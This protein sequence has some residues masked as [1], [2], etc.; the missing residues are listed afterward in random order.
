M[1]QVCVG[2]LLCF[3]SLSQAADFPLSPAFKTLQHPRNDIAFTPHGGAL[4]TPSRSDVLSAI[5]NQSPVRDQSGRGTCSIFSATAALE[6]LLVRGGYAAPGVNLSEEWL[7][8]LTTQSQS[9]EG[10]TSANNFMLLREWGQPLEKSLPYGGQTWTS[11]SS[12]LALRRC[13]YLKRGP[14]LRACLTSHRNPDLLKMNDE[15]LLNPNEV[16]YDPEFVV[17]RKEAL[18]ARDAYL[19]RAN[20]HDGIVTTVSEIHQLLAAGIPLT[21]DI[22]FFWGAWNYPG[23]AE[24]G[25]LRSKEY[26]ENGTITYPEKGSVDRRYS[27]KHPES[28]SVVVVGYDDDVEVTYTMSMRNG[29][30]QI[31]TR[32]GVYYFKNSWGTDTWGKNF[33]VNGQSFPGYGM[34]LQDN[35]HEFGEFYHLDL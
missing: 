3:A 16:Y 23:S 11:K 10:S 9:S 8:Y 24:K 33:Q 4:G 15:E 26:W 18:M 29:K 30:R 12:G 7:Q 32:K 34:I 13:G 28:H 22:D 25:I 27:K 31:F 5:H 14:K 6:G 1:R 19:S 35:A 2:V 17:A 20:A 21:L